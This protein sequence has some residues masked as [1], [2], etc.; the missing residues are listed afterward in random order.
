MWEWSWLEIFL[1]YSCNLKCSFCFQKDL[2]YK[3]PKFV[4][5][6][7]VIGIID[8]WVKEWKKSI[9]FSWWESTLDPNLLQYIVYCNKNWFTDIRVHTNWLTFSD[10]N[11]LEKY[12]HWWIT[13]V[14]LS[15]HWYWK[16]HDYLVDKQGAFEKVKTTL[17]HLTEIKKQNNKFVIDTNTVLN[18]FNYKNLDVLFKFLSYFPITRSQIVQLYSLYLFS[19]IE[20]S[21]LY[22]SYEKFS[23][24][25]WKIFAVN[26]N[27][28]L[29]N[30][31]FC[32]VDKQYWQWIIKRQKYDNE[33]YW[34]MWEGFEESD[35][36]YVTECDWCSYKNECVWIPKDY[37]W[38]FPEEKFII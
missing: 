33:A 15:I 18:K 37:L 12:I 21:K 25:I 16:M 9:V 6:D 2:R 38:V 8:L 22:I 17:L 30:F 19:D 11:V 5:F 26:K 1:W 31:P 10:K 4:S 14:I 13:W 29:E 3:E 20:K 34:N 23:P 28:T 36:T 32:K 24:E 27:V 7:Y 35:C